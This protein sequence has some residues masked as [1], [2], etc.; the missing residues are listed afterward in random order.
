MKQKIFSGQDKD[1]LNKF[2]QLQLRH[3]TDKIYQKS[4]YD[5][6]VNKFE[7]EDKLPEL[8]SKYQNQLMKKDEGHLDN[9]VQD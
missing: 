6:L 4:I 8:Y 3:S 1:F 2:K 7:K 5:S 9:L